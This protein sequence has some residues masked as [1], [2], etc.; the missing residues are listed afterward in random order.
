[1][2][3]TNKKFNV[4]A[5]VAVIIGLSGLGLLV[6]GVANHVYGFSPLSVQRHAWM[7]AHN[8]LGLLF[9]AFSICHVVL[10]RRP[11]WNY[12]NDAALR[13]PS[14]SREAIVAGLVVACALGAFVGHAFLLGRR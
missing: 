7:S 9:V 10:N 12:V 4:R 13:A 3:S 1:M 5:F 2:A 6:T 11:L 14:I 8:T